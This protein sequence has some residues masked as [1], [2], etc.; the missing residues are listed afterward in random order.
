MHAHLHIPDPPAGLAGCIF[1]ARFVEDT[2]SIDVGSPAQVWPRP[3]V[4]GYVYLGI[5]RRLAN[6][7][8]EIC[9]LLGNR[10][11]SSIA[12]AQPFTSHLAAAVQCLQ[13]LL[14][15]SDDPCP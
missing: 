11:H 3:S 8:L 9:L 6:S 1:G 4:S 12:L 13:W 5:A 14:Q 10:D 15:C 2:H 7:V